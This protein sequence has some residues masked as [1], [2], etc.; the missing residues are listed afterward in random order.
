M[1]ETTELLHVLSEPELDALIAEQG[2]VMQRRLLF[3]I[4]AL[5]RAGQDVV[6]NAVRLRAPEWPLNQAIE[7]W[8]MIYWPGVT[9]KPKYAHP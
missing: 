8:K 2:D 9:P 4:R 5:Q 1:P 7:R 6:D 3:T